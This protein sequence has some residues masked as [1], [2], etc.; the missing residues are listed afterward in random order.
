MEGL[1]RTMH[2]REVQA[3]RHIAGGPW[4]SATLIENT[5]TFFLSPEMYEKHNMP[6]Q[7]DFVE[8]MHTTGKAA[9]LHMCG[10]VHA[11]L[12]LIK[13]TGCDGIHASHAPSH[14]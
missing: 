2:Q 8:A 4:E 6:H 3:F 10:H 12:D 7:R 13:E 9:I 5:S 11:L 1:I 14:G